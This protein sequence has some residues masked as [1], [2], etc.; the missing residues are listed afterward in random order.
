MTGKQDHYAVLGVPPD[1]DADQIR[2]AHRR[3][4]WQVH[5]DR[6]GPDATAEEKRRAHEAA[7]A[8]N[9][10]KA[11][12]TD[13]GRR[14]R[15]DRSILLEPE[16]VHFSDARAGDFRSASF[17]ISNPGGRAAHEVDLI[18]DFDRSGDFA[19]EVTWMEPTGEAPFPLRIKFRAMGTGAGRAYR[20]S[21]R[22]RAGRSEAV[23]VVRLTT[24]ARPA[25][26]RPRPVIARP[27]PAAAPTRPAATRTRP[28]APRIRPAATRTRP[29]T[30]Q[31]PPVPARTR[32]TSARRVLVPLAAGLFGLGLLVA[33]GA[34]V[35]LVVARIAD[36]FAGS[37]PPPEEPRV[38]GGDDAG[39][40]GVGVAGGY[41]YDADDDGLIEIATL[42][43][44]D[45][46]RWDLDGDGVPAASGSG[47][48]AD[49]FPE[50]ARGRGCISDRCIGYELTVGL[51]FDTNGNG[52]ADAGDRYW[53]GG[54]GWEPI[55][56]VTPVR[57]GVTG[58]GFRA[59]FDG[60]GHAVANLFV[61]RPTTDGVG[62][63]GAVGDWTMSEVPGRS[64][65]SG[66]VIRNVHLASVEV[67]GRDQVGGLA[68]RNRGRLSRIQATGEVTGGEEVGGLVGYNDRGALSAGHAAGRV[69]GDR[70]IGGLVGGNRG[71]V[72]NS[73]A[74]GGITGKEG[75]GGLIGGNWGRVSESHAAARVAGERAVGELVGTEGG[76]ELMASGPTPAPER[77]PSGR[78]RPP[79]PRLGP[80]A[81]PAP[82]PSEPV[83]TGGDPEP[84]PVGGDPGQF[85][86]GGDPEPIR[87]GGD[88]AAPKRVRT[89]SA[90]YPAVARDF[91]VEGVV[92]LR[93]VIGPD[94]GVREAEVLRSPRFLDRPAV[95]AV[96][97]WRYEPTVLYGEAV[98]VTM[99]E[100]VR[101][102]LGDP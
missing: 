77:A 100:T 86:V 96:R 94:G 5:P 38:S 34:V 71:T 41:D 47:A 39:A 16:E 58:E 60:G 2:E 18:R 30:P 25:A 6:L 19:L 92:I 76:D 63:F 98:P 42:A 64:H 1:A 37:G 81:D 23:C 43:Q 11:E 28:A 46:I 85:P 3:R 89:V 49:A 97:Q 26:T 53:N 101:F 20:G 52:V 93:I 79:V 40:E 51:D 70:Y 55:G 74:A 45:A 50:P 84:I 82:D 29:A 95:R 62:L 9:L 57:G 75:V 17:V 36:R 22:V 56:K 8:L 13:P 65:G 91:R 88:I 48:Y 27:P 15:F 87:V 68:G 90:V 102:H 12:L 33:L 54:A 7:V 83:A 35:G 31:A 44:L 32:R 21:I 72:S 80:R 66:G 61:N 59:I 78:V 73:F 67:T 69:A 24:R 99:T 14:D 10:A 4:T